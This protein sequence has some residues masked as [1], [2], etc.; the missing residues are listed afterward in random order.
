VD[1]AAV[2]VGVLDAGRA[3]AGTGD[4]GILASGAP[5]PSGVAGTVHRR[6]SAVT[7]SRAVR[8]SANFSWP[9]PDERER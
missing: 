5:R 7:R 2:P 6:A 3:T 4:V 1:N 9:G 8:L